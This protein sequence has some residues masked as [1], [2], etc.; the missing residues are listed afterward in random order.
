MELA[1]SAAALPAAARLA[2]LN[3]QCPDH[4]DVVAE[5]LD[6]VAWE[7]KMGDFLR[8]PIVARA[9]PRAELFAPGSLVAGRYRIAREIGR[10][11][12]T[13]VYEA[14]DTQAELPVA[15]K[16]GNPPGIAGP[17]FHAGLVRRHEYAEVD[18]AEGRFG[19]AVFEYLAGPPLAARL[20]A[21][22]PL[23]VED[24]C[25]IALCLCRV[26]RHAATAGFQPASLN[27]SDIILAPR[28][29]VLICDWLVSGGKSHASAADL[30]SLG[31]ILRRLAPDSGEPV[32]AAWNRIVHRC[33][34]QVPEK[35]YLSLT[36]LE[37]D[38]RLLPQLS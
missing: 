22:P 24:A 4:P 37:E 29:P 33:M 32:A 10:G 1:E 36:A 14:R 21:T 34:G 31:L 17:P 19:F 15:L 30:A 5:I 6:R 25:A 9:A 8:E 23:P 2:W 7:E 11:R 3:A 27:T 13:T 28:G 16:V 26:L 35:R 20:K 12:W 18:S 38:L